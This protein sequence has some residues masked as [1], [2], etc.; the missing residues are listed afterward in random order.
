[1]WWHR[2]AHLKRPFN[3]QIIP[4]STGDI[5]GSEAAHE[6]LIRQIQTLTTQN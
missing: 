3:H 4:Q 1:M 6:I 2:I 5:S